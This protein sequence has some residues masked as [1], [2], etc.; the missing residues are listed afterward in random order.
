MV[1]ER[2]TRNYFLKSNCFHVRVNSFRSGKERLQL[3]ERRCGRNLSMS[4]IS[5]P[6]SSANLFLFILEETC[7]MRQNLWISVIRGIIT[8]K[9]LNELSK[10]HRQT[11][12]VGIFFILP[13]SVNLRQMLS[14]KVFP[15]EVAKVQLLWLHVPTCTSTVRKQK[16]CL[17]T[18]A[19]K[20]KFPT[21]HF[22]IFFSLHGLQWGLHSNMLEE[23]WQI[24]ASKSSYLI[25]TVQSYVQVKFFFKLLG[26]N[27]HHISSILDAIFRSFVLLWRR[28]LYSHF[29]YICGY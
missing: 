24:K 22:F 20:E 19:R 1:T 14:S 23:R 4:F 7:K 5:K 8:S 29:T 10:P 28:F 2:R 6:S 3:T 18:G 21:S 12:S 15:V 25:T 11:D 13:L 17:C 27:V 16:R 9:E 26:T